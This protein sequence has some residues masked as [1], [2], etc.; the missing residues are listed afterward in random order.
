MK[1]IPREK[2]DEIVALHRHTSMSYKEIA[3]RVGCSKCGV[4]GVLKQWR[5]T[6]S[7]ATSRAGHCGS[8]EKLTSREKVAIVRESKKDFTLS[9]REIKQQAGAPGEKVSRTPVHRILHQAGRKAYRP[10]YTPLISRQSRMKRLR[11]A[12]Q[13]VGKSMDDWKKVQYSLR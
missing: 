4:F 10:I 7:T 5:E 12:R 1:D 9:L 6:G 2:R 8:K 13:H 11:W 3:E